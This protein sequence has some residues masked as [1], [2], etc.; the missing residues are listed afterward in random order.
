MTKI[1]V[2]AFI[3]LFCTAVFAEDISR[4]EEPPVEKKQDAGFADS[5]VRIAGFFAVG[6]P[7][8]GLFQKEQRVF[9]AYRA[10]LLKAYLLPRDYRLFDTYMGGGG[11]LDV[12]PPAVRFAPKRSFDFTGIKFGIRGRYGYEFVD[13]MIVDEGSYFIRV[14]GYELFRAKTMGYH[15]CAAG[16]VM[17]LIFGPR[18]N[19]YNFLISFYALV[20]PVFDGTYRGAAALR[21]ARWLAVELFG[22]YGPPGPF[23]RNIHLVAARYSN[24]TRFS[25]YTVRCG[26][27]PHIALN[28]QFPFIIGINVVYAFSRIRLDTPLLIFCD[29]DA[30]ASHHE[31][32]GEVS[33]GVH[34]L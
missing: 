19:V 17:D 13:S 21:S 31:V 12:M 20:G 10:D 26:L 30:R 16:P 15:Y 24:R 22:A 32:G 8:G 11:D 25:G 28:G 14:E 27:G 7:S 3:T 18:S 6:A 23:M 4:S 33:V 9:R 5:W 1:T 2:L 29:T 34:I